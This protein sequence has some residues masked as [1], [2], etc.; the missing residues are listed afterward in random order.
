MHWEAVSCSEHNYFLFDSCSLYH[1]SRNKNTF[2]EEKNGDF[3]FFFLVFTPTLLV[4]ISPTEAKANMRS[5]V[6]MGSNL[7]WPRT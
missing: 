1:V 7:K 3:F 6:T 2:L 4:S 5:R